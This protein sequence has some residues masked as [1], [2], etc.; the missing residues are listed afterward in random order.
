[1]R[2]IRNPYHGSQ[3]R[4]LTYT[5]MEAGQWFLDDRLVKREQASELFAILRTLIRSV[6]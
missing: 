4:I 3:E 6:G 5:I 2:T 1:M